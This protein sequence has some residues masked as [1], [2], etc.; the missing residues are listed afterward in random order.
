MIEY[1]TRAAPVYQ[2]KLDGGHLRA[3]PHR[4]CTGPIYVH[5]PVLLPRC[6][7]TRKELRNSDI[8]WCGSGWSLCSSADR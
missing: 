4:R 7:A 3:S 8:L 6:A 2:L 5:S 1:A